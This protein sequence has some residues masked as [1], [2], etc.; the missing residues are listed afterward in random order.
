MSQWKPKLSQ[1]FLKIGLQ[2]CSVGSHRVILKFIEGT[3]QNHL[4]SFSKYTHQV[5]CM[6][7]LI[8]WI[9]VILRSCVLK[10]SIGTYIHFQIPHL[11]SE[12]HP[13]ERLGKTEVP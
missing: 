2:I 11:E 7:I 6:E 9:R 13:C 12:N 5:L 10:S 1:K 8:L 3:H 4:E